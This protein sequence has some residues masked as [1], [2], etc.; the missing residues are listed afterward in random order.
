MQTI[1]SDE[2][3]R[4][5]RWAATWWNPDGPMKPL[6]RMNGLRA[7]TLLEKAKNAFGDLRGLKVLDVG[8]GGG[9][10]SEA[11]AKAGAQVVG[12]DAA[13]RNIES[14]RLHAAQEGLD[15]DYRAGEAAEA[16]HADEQFD[17]VLLLE[18]VEHVDNLPE[19]FAFCAAKVKPGGM[20]AVSTINRTPA[21]WLVAIVGAEYVLKVLPKGTHQWKQFVTPRE[22]DLL[23]QNCG[24]RP[25][26]T[27][28]MRYDP[29]R[30]QASWCKTRAVNYM[31]V[32]QR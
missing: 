19:F 4:Y 7:D 18:V 31:T 23:A 5:N 15:I 26:F 3:D 29:F 14:A 12:I 25:T 9:L 11:F 22:T 10:M 8:C 16:L 20:L 27:T 17:I 21:S 32:F 30:H 2:R 24:F 6:H 28:G 13:E 1:R